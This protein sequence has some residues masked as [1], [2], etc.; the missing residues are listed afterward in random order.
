MKTQ[1][2]KLPSSS[3][4]SRSLDERLGAAHVDTAS[5]AS[6]RAIPKPAWFDF[7]MFS[8]FLAK[9]QLILDDSSFTTFNDINKTAV[10]QL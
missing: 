8:G 2:V 3:I 9:L 4:H 1:N 5:V 10:V 6:G 7:S